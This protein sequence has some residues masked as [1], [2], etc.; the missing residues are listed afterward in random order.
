MPK[1]AESRKA[2]LGIIVRYRAELKKTLTQALGQGY[3]PKF[4]PINQKKRNSKRKDVRRVKGG[5][6]GMRRR[7]VQAYVVDQVRK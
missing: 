4:G 6:Y 3:R 1:R 5:R 2:C 7:G